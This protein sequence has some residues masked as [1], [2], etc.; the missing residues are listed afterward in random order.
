MRSINKISTQNPAM[1]ALPLQQF[2]DFR[3]V[4]DDSDSVHEEQHHVFIHDHSGRFV[5]SCTMSTTVL[6]DAVLAGKT[7]DW[8]VVYYD[9]ET[10]GSATICPRCA[11]GLSCRSSDS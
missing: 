1:T 5:R 6:V 11:V 7:D 8:N 4:G 2:Q 9:Q 3:Q 10:G